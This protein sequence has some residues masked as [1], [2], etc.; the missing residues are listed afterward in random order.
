MTTLMTRMRPLASH[1]TRIRLRTRRSPVRRAP[2]SA[3]DER[4]VSV[5]ELAVLQARLVV[6]TTRAR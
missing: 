2:F 1:T 4:L 5:S 3:A 6:G